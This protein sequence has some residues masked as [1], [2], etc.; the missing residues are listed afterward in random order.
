MKNK[1]DESLLD[2]AKNILGG[3]WY[4]KVYALIVIAGIVYLL[5]TVEL[6]S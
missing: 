2:Q 3:P 1:N 6:F 5:G 4:S